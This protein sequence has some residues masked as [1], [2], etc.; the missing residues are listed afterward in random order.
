[1]GRDNH[2]KERQK[3]DLARKQAKHINQGR[4]RILIVSEGKKTEP[5]YFHEI[6][7]LSRLPKSLV[8]IL[9]CEI[10]TDPEN[11]VKYAHKLLIEGREH[12]PKIQPKA[13]ERVYVVFDRD[14]HLTYKEALEKIN[15]LNNTLKNDNKQPVHFEAIV[16]VPC[17]E[18]WLLLHYEDIKSPL[19]RKEVLSRLKKYIP[20]YEKGSNNIFE[21]TC[22]YI[23]LAT[24]RAQKLIE[25]HNYPPEKEPFTTIINLTEYLYNKDK[26]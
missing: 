21:I 6:R 17:F 7:R 18:L 25:K 9:P 5:N 13:F 11:I 23:K 10:G 24:E 1:M 8:T 4:D 22:K 15:K 3:K 16:S 20:D 2:P 12:A 19:N 26:I 14:E